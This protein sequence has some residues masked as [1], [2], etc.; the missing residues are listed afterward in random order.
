MKQPDKKYGSEV[1]RFTGTL[2]ILILF[3]MVALVF[4]GSAIAADASTLASVN[5]M[6][7]SSRA[8][9]GALRA[10]LTRIGHRELP[11]LRMQRLREEKLMRALPK[12][13]IGST[14]INLTNLP[15]RKRHSSRATFALG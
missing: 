13:R 8:V 12:S 4:P 15:F 1:V 10:Y 6:P 2:I 9:D 11:A 7:I 5:Q 3:A 14:P